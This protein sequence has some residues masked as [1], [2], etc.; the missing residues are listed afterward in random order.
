V[1]ACLLAQNETLTAQPEESEKETG[2][3]KRTVRLSGLSFFLGDLAIIAGG[4]VHA[5][6]KNANRHELGNAL[7][8]LLWA[9]A[10]V[11]SALYGNPKKPMQ[12]RIHAHN[13]EEYLA[14]QGVTI[15][16]DIRQQS[17]LLHDEGAHEKMR[18]FISK[19][20]TEVFNTI[21]GGAAVGMVYSGA[22]ALAVGDKPRVNSLWAG[23]M[24]MGGALGGLLI[25]EDPNA[26]EKARGG[27]FVQRGIAYIREKPLRFTSTLYLLNDYFIIQRAVHEF[28]EF[29]A[30]GG[31]NNHFIYPT[32]AAAANVVGNGLLFL[33]SRNQLREGYSNVQIGEFEDLAA[34]VVVR[35]APDRGGHTADTVA[36]YMHHEKISERPIEQLRSE[37]LQRAD[38]L[39]GKPVSH[40]E[41]LL[42]EPSMEAGRG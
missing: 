36:R 6:G 16:D 15:P 32:I 10:G 7:T 8:G 12:L 23:L 28:K 5:R 41:R 3:L 21:I 27:N 18:R 35:Q 13:L 19:H 40:Q 14:K 31:R 17:V 26:R 34:Q 4:L 11:A 30:T 24:V 9:Q 1:E 37:I 33:S 29:K 20:P 2:W 39:D 25:K 38:R 42:A 22:K